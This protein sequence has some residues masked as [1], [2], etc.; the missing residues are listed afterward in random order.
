[1]KP[2]ERVMAL[3]L[4]DGYSKSEIERAFH[5][6]DVDDYR[7]LSAEDLEYSEGDLW[8]LVEEEILDNREKDWANVQYKTCPT[9]GEKLPLEA[10]SKNKRRP[11]GLQSECKRCR[12][13]RRYPLRP[14]PPEPD[15]LTGDEFQSVYSNPELKQFVKKQ[16]I[17]HAK[18]SMENQEDWKQVVWAE[19]YLQAP[20][21]LGEAKTVAL[22]TVQ[23]EYQN[24]RRSTGKR[25]GFQ[26][27]H[28]KDPKDDEE[29]EP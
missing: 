5:A 9:C 10:F 26:E 16:C 29:D 2:L 24:F 4:A 19:I 15:S 25:Y 14:R 28:P 27:V 8:V 1:M 22:K 6:F 7:D 18:N 21:T 12:H 3:L 17:R 20:K 13:R 11:D 23:R